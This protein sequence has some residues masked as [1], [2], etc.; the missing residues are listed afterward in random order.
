MG[1]VTK[2]VVGIR[3]RIWCITGCVVLGWA[4]E[5]ANLLMDHQLCRYGILPRTTWGLLG[6]PLCP[7]LHGSVTHLVLNTVPFAVLGGLVALR[8]KIIF[9]E[10]SASIT[11]LGGLGVWLLGRPS[12]HV[13]AS[14]LVFGYFG[15]LVAR[16]WYERSLGSMIVASVTFF[17]Y[18]GLLWGVLPTVPYVSWE[19]HLCGLIAGI[20][21]ARARK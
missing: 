4:V 16:G 14:G 15:Y 6:V 11:V 20:L 13:G 12:Y 17:L 7:L 8:G 2:R 18:G 3:D 1:S 21:A 10:V 5:L 9:V 19:A